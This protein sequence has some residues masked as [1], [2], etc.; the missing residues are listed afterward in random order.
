MHIY[1]NPLEPDVC[2]ILA[3]GI[4]VVCGRMY[5]RSG[6]VFEGS[7]EQEKFSKWLEKKVDSVESLRGREI[8]TQSFR[9]GVLSHNLSHSSI[10]SAISAL[11]RG[12]W[13]IGGLL[14]RYIMQLMHADE[15][16]GRTA[17]GLPPYELELAMLPA[18]FKP[19]AVVEFANIITDYSSYPAS[20]A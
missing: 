7:N 12:G 10:L 6:R 20:N 5:P 2:C 19:T 3:L 18:R 13:S 17:C 9:K 11:L 1:A 8:G 4:Y 15:V 16:I 14:P